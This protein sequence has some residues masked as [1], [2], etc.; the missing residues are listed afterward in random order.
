MVID[1][2]DTTVGGWYKPAPIIN[3]LRRAEITHPLP[4]AVTP[5]GNRLR[6]AFV[7]TPSED[8]QDIPNFTQ[9]VNIGK[10][11]PKW[12][13]DGRPYMRWNRNAD[14]YRLVAE[15]DYAF[16]CMRLAIT[17]LLSDDPGFMHR[18]GDTPVKTWVRWLTLALA[19]RY[20][21]S[22]EYQA[23]VSVICAYYYHT[24]LDE[25]RTLSVS[26]RQALSN[27]VSR[28][29]AVPVPTVLEMIEPVGPLKTGDDLAT[30]LR[31]HA[32]TLGLTQLKFVDLYT[33]V[34]NS[35]IGVN[36]RENVG[37]ALEHIP[38]FIAMVYYALSERS[39]RKTVI[40]R[41]AETTG[42]QHELQQFTNGL[43]RYISGRFE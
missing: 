2:Y 11:S 1:P 23:R 29:T 27:K 8:F 43:F 12:V 4:S 36:A 30:A 10:D 21:L 17:Q 5:T 22:L 6:D 13:M 41:R 33:L 19:Q 32:G 39:Y 18:L 9:F 42:R 16:Q 25:A 31:E 28:V 34:A 7:V 20:N 14:S 26:E 37:L 15:N 38:T 40:T 3:A 35:W 24:Q